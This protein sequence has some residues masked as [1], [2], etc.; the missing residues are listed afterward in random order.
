MRTERRRLRALGDA[1]VRDL[2]GNVLPF[3]ARET[4]DETHGG[5]L[6]FLSEEAVPE[7]LAP[8]GGVLCARILWTYS[9]A[10]LARGTRAT[11]GWPTALSTSSPDASGMPSTADLL[12]LDGSGRPLSDRKQTYALAFSL[13]GL[14]EYHRATGS[15]EALER[16]IGLY[17][18]I[19]AHASDTA[20]GGYEEARAR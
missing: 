4:V 9:A 16:A 2:E 8:K 17:R 1:L 6:G 18:A 15:A 20:H 14:A 12:D 19:E 11:G 3:W 13:Y 7:P 10:L 5:F